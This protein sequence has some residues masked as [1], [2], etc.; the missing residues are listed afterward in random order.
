MTFIVVVHVDN[1]DAAK[2]LATMV[3]NADDVPEMGVRVVGLYAWP[4]P[5]ELTCAGFCSDGK[6]NPWSFGRRGMTCG[7]CGGRHVDTK[8][9]VAGALRQYLGRNLLKNAPVPF[10]NPDA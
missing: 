4:T 5:A 10:R 2:T 6:T 7:V 8:K 9:R 3:T 1:M